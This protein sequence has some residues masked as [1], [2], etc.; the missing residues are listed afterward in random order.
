MIVATAAIALA[1]CP[2]SAAVDGNFSF[3]SH[4]TTPTKPAANQIFGVQAPG[5]SRSIEFESTDNTSVLTNLDG[6][7]SASYDYRWEF[8]IVRRPHGTTTDTT[9]VVKQSVGY[10][11]YITWAATAGQ[12]ITVTVGTVND[13]SE[14]ISVGEWDAYTIGET[15]TSGALDGEASSSITF[16]LIQ[17]P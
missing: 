7:N 17:F 8:R 2:A 15:R 9:V 10:P 5:T 14:S 1:G 16:E 13:P 3:V 12:Q 6:L 4:P 11:S